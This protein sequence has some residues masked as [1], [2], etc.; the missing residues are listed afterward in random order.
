MAAEPKMEVP[1][2]AVGIQGFDAITGGGLPRGRVTLVLGAS[3]SGK[4]VFAMEFLAGG[5]VQHNE[6]GAFVS[7][8]ENEEELAANF[9]SFGFELKRLGEEK[10]LIVEYIEVTPLLGTEAGDY[11]LTGLLLRL[12]RAIEKVGARRVVL[13][14]IPVLFQG[15]TDTAAV[16]IA[17]ATL[18]AWLKERNITSVVTAESDS[19]LARYGLGR[20][21]SDCIVRLSMRVRDRIATRYL[22]VTKYRGSAHQSDEFPFLISGSGFSVLPVTSV[23]PRYEASSERISTGIP[24]LDTMLGGD[25][26]F[27]GSSILVSGEAG[28]GKTS[29]AVT[30]VVAACL[31]GERCLYC[32]FEESEG[33]ICRNMRSIGIDLQRYLEEKLLTFSMYRSTH[34]GLELH[35]V[36]LEKEIQDF[37]P[38]VTVFD[39]ISNLTAA[40]SFSEV[41][42]MTSRLLD[43]LKSNG[44]SSLFTALVSGGAE[45]SSSVVGV[46][47][48]MDTWIGLRNLENEGEQ[49]RLISIIKSRGMAHSNQVREFLI[50]DAGIELV[51]VYL[52]PSGILTGTA[53]AAEEARLKDEQRRRRWE[54]ERKKRE[55]E[56]K[57]AV[58]EAR[59]AA[60]QAELETSGDDLRQIMQDAADHEKHLSE[61][62]EEIARRR[63]KDSR[64]E[65]GEKK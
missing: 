8:E 1:K 42:S 21:L 20:S 48:L 61:Q 5:A 11:D 65:V 51:D 60:L 12:E 49:T 58:I 44:V 62:Q 35:L 23:L 52:G 37:R 31:R 22:Q 4:T 26:Y 34:A 43:F 46:S 57:R 50:T 24:R 9:H 25:G 55:H 45:D 33:E 36:N 30:L 2:A 32:A 6:A 15:F 41:K 47:S 7:F 19:E 63:W 29:L 28:T 54:I 64:D 18:F 27:R 17:L 16:R 56:H 39:P 59:I 14:A 10:R 53:R 13:D 3:G 40:G 38:Q